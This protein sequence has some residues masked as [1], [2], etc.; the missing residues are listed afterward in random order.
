MQLA[1]HLQSPNLYRDTI[2][3]ILGQRTVK[4]LNLPSEK[5]WVF[6]YFRQE[7][8]CRNLLAAEN[9]NHCQLRRWQCSQAKSKG[10]LRILLHKKL[11]T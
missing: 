9:F 4:K 8:A 7:L 2:N 3:G 11:Q 10:N 1:F 5:S 6:E